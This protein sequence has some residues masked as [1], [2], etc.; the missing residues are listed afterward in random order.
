MTARDS[1]V[2][3]VL[4][5]LAVACTG[6]DGSLATYQETVNEPTE[7]LGPVTLV[8]DSAADSLTPVVCVFARSGPADVALLWPARWHWAGDGVTYVVDGDNQSRAA[9]G[10]TV[11][12]TGRA[13]PGPWPDL[14]GCPDHGSVWQVASVSASQPPAIR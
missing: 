12:L 13:Q 3:V 6:Q 5:A 8:V 11:W 7:G 9:I 1:L 2:L 4:A 10:D 14:R